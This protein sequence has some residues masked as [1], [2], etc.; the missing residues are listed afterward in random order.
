MCCDGRR[1]VRSSYRVP[2][3]P[4]ILDASG[5]VSITRWSWR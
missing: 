1:I 4:V 2:C 5:D 3:H